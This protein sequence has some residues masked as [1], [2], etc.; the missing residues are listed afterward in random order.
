[1]KVKVFVEDMVFNIS[2]GQGLN[3]LA[4]LSLVAAKLYGKNKVKL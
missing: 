2:I 3:D 1:M 4:W